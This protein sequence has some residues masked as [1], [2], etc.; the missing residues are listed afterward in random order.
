MITPT[1]GGVRLLGGTLVTPPVVI[2]VIVRVIGGKGT[3]LGAA[4]PTISLVC[5]LFVWLVVCR[6]FVLVRRR[7]RKV[8]GSRRECRKSDMNGQG[9]RPTVA[10]H[11]EKTAALTE[12]WQELIN[13]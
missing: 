8:D 2:L 5:R 10:R 9:K 7:N 3:L 13:D 4:A 6:L 12:P 11:L 1:V